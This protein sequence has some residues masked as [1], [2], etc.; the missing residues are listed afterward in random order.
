MFPFAGIINMMTVVKQKMKRIEMTTNIVNNLKRALM[1]REVNNML[2]LEW[3][4]GDC[5]AKGAESSL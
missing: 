3:S 1:C 4:N 2:K 5:V